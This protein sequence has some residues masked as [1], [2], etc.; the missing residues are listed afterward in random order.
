GIFVYVG[1]EVTIGSYL[2]NYFLDLDIAGLTAGSGLMTGLVTFFSGSEPGSLNVERL[3]GTFVV[4]YWGGAMVG[5]FIGS[6]LQ[7]YIRPGRLLTVYAAVNV[8]LLL[9]TMNLAGSAAVW[10]ILAIGLFNSI[11][12]P[13]IFTT[14]I[15]RLGENTAQG[16]GIL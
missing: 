6:Y 4:F 16:S 2:V 15:D 12:F 13:T 11:M 7:L 10:S 5:R 3:A 8:L 14:A 9:L 1:A